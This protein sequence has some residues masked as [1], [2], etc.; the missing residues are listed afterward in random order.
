MATPKGFKATSQLMNIGGS[1]VEAIAGT[2]SE[3]EINLPLSTLDREVFIVTDV[4]MALSTPEAIVATDTSMIGQVTRTAQGGSSN[5]A[6]PGTISL[7]VSVIR[8]GVVGFEST[9]PSDISS[10]GGPNDYLAV[11]A[12]P[13]FF[14]GVVGANNV[15]AGLCR[16]RLTGF[17][18][19]AEASLYA[20][21][22]TEE[23][24]S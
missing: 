7:K 6:E 21:L 15:A 1:A 11:I 3:A 13:Q 10:S 16:A 8:Q 24:N 23:L 17:R 5:I 9:N 12:T 20:A 4:Q 19:V 2:F 18:A 14:V 22:V